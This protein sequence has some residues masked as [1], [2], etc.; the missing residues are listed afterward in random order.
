[1]PN[2]EYLMKPHVQIL[3]RPSPLQIPAT[4]EPIEVISSLKR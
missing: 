3:M 1:M 4:V 2:A